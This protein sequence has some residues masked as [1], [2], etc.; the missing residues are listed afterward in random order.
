MIKSSK[1]IKITMICTNIMI[2]C[3]KIMIICVKIMIICI[4]IIMIATLT[5]PANVVDGLVVH[6][7]GTVGVLQCRVR[8]QYRVVW[9]HN[10]CRHLENTEMIDILG[11]EKGLHSRGRG[12]CVGLELRQT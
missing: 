7:E 6:H 9:L 8:G 3:V 12:D 1:C 2:L 5:I 10:C 4:N 11:L